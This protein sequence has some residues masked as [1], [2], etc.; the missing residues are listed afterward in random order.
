MHKPGLFQQS[1]QAT[2]QWIHR[3]DS[4]GV[5][6]GWVQLSSTWANKTGWTLA[7]TLLLHVFPHFQEHGI[8]TIGLHRAGLGK[9]RLPSSEST[10]QQ[11]CFLRCQ[12]LTAPDLKGLAKGGLS[13]R[14]PY[15]NL[16]SLQRSY[17]PLP[18]TYT[19]TFTL[20]QNKLGLNS[21]S[22]AT[23]GQKKKIWNHDPHFQ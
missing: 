19:T 7:S 5:N 22:S 23:S 9:A 20:P 17:V 4:A 6:W 14:P 16:S 1:I 13:R 10:I 21:S 8:P 18:S 12:P 3:N 15:P 2:R 11:L